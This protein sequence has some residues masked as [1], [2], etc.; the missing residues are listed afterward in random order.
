MFIKKICKRPRRVIISVRITVPL[1]P[2]E[3]YIYIY[4]Y[5]YSTS[6]CVHLPQFEYLILLL[7]KKK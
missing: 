3:V 2:L 1:L 6:V 5:I 4:I 7:N